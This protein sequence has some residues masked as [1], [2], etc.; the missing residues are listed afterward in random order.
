[1]SSIAGAKVIG[2]VA[3][4][5]VPDTSDF[6]RDLRAD[7]KKIE[8][9]LDARIQVRVELH[10]ASL[11]KVQKEL[12][13]WARKISP[14][15]ISVVP[16]LQNGV[17]AYISARLK[18]LTR[19]RF[20]TII[21]R[22][23]NGAYMRVLTLLSA[24]SG[25]RSLSNIFE[26]VWDS[27]KNLDKAI[28]IIAGL[29]L[30]IVGLAGYA[31]TAMGNIFALT[32]SIVEIG[33]AAL[34]LPGIFGGLAIGI[35]ASIAVLKDFNKVLPEVKSAFQ[36]LQ[37][38]M[39][40]VFWKQAAEPIR[41]LVSSVMPQLIQ[42]LRATS[43]ALG[44]WFGSF[45]DSV[46]TVI[47]PILQSTFSDLNQSINIAAGYTDHFVGILA[48]LGV[49]GAGYL[50]RLATWFG[51]ISKR[52]DGWL[53]KVQADGRLVNWV[54]TALF[55]FHELGRAL[56]NLGG[57][58][59]GLAQAAQLGGGS[60]LTMFADTLQ[61]I[62][63][64]VKGPVFQSVLVG[65]LRAAHDAM[66]QIA[67]TSGPSV[68][69]FFETLGRTLTTVFPIVGDT[70][71]TAFKAVFSALSQPEVSG[72][73]VK[74]FQGIQQGVNGLAPAMAP[75][76]K[77]LGSLMEI[78]GA[79]A[80]NLGPI[81]GKAIS[82]IAP[83]IQAIAGP[84]IGIINNLG[85][86]VGA[87]MGQL[88]GPMKSA[89]PAIGGLF[90]AI[91]EAIKPVVKF[92][93]E[94]GAAV[95]PM[96]I[97]ALKTIAERLTPVFKIIGQLVTFIAPIAK[98]IITTVIGV[99]VDTIVTLIKGI[100]NFITGIKSIFTGISTIIQ[101]FKENSWNKIWTGIKEVFMGVWNVI[102]GAFQIFISVGMI[103]VIR[104][105]LAVLK[106]LWSG[107]WNAIKTVVEVLWESIK[108]RWTAFITGIRTGATT[109]L[110]GIKTL[111]KTVWDD[112][113]LAV[114]LA[115]EAIKLVFTSQLNGIKTIFTVTFNFIRNF[116][117]RAWEGI[118]FIFVSQF[119]PIRN[120]VTLIWD[121]VRN[122][123]SRGVSSALNLVKSMPGKIKG[124]F[125]DAG[126]WLL[127]AG[128]KI[129]DGLV[130]GI[131]SAFHKVKEVLSDLTK[132]LPDWKGPPSYD[133]VLLV[134]A[135]QSII[136]GFI[137][138]LESRY[139]MVRR[140]LKS[141]SEDVAGTPFELASVT[142]GNASRLA[143]AI[144]AAGGSG[145]TNQRTLNYYAAPGNSLD[146]EE[147]LFAAASRA[148]M[149]TW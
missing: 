99:I 93:V 89:A 98:F 47:G 46:R 64:T 133:K 28:P 11:Q 78:I 30:S 63:T 73:L 123:F 3:I 54:E 82:A 39:S 49:I 115:W 33:P 44:K 13:H 124:F 141:L 72:G 117:S 27:L 101:G 35:G 90:A 12:Q 31:L 16:N 42:S 148:R 110:S 8:K 119:S 71:G 56:G 113:K 50:P 95:I 79:L 85:S 43:V 127:D 23:D 86:G 137:T 92:L 18:F 25:A 135:G 83:V 116:L 5:V 146:S 120:A 103:G 68:S 17:S 106:G 143:A 75:L 138:G 40:A 84:L 81:L 10:K 62:E 144:S 149:V 58:L 59:H 1:M 67:S 147:D 114:G 118:K 22:L 66:S 122:V 88:A 6:K 48:K 53:G 2:K 19:P 136:D 32:Q 97:G 100:S 107:T 57:V 142:G 91:G 129:I 9:T 74:M 134:G 51:E 26:N 15:K 108:A 87:I 130:Q 121:T 7:L 77:M 139:S 104:K 128:R 145:T 112:I 105:G 34:L 111:F 131:K 29:S 125:A 21:P 65:T 37:N 132:S 69:K 140:S 14:L 102:V 96:V 20:A 52:F 126:K 60:G 36:D 45:A 70:I 55:Q 76:G 94:L 109:F 41:E 24:L 80:A 38:Q 61:R 4:K